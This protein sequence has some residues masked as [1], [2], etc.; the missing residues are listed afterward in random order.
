MILRLIIILVLL[1]FPRLCWAGDILGRVVI[2][3]GHG[4]YDP[5]ATRKGIMEKQINLEVSQEIKKILKENNVEVILTREG[6]YNL[7]IP[8]LHKK[9]AKRYDFDKRIELAKTFGADAMVSIHVNVSRRKCTGPE[10]FYYKKST[11][12]KLLAE[13]IQKELHQIRG[14]NHRTVKTGSYYLLTHTSMPCVIV[15]TG[16]INNPEEREKLLDKKH[17][18]A[19]AKAT[20]QGIVDYLKAKDNPPSG[21]LKVVDSLQSIIAYIKEGVS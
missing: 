19:L 8:G 18:Q 12:G 6:D 16:F 9:E 17:Q 10:A 13:C 14:M 20:S 5:G 1:L 7:A 11:Q 15:E 3:P 21:D 2:D 4:G